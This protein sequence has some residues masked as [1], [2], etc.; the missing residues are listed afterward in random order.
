[1]AQGLPSNEQQQFCDKT[2]YRT[3]RHENMVVMAKKAQRDGDIT[4]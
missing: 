4:L 2:W 1:M 3:V